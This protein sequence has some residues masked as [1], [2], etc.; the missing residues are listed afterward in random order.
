MNTFSLKNASY[1]ICLIVV[2]LAIWAFAIMITNIRTVNAEVKDSWSPE[3]A[4]DTEW[5]S[6]L[7]TSD[8]EWPDYDL[9]GF[10]KALCKK[11]GVDY[12]ENWYIF[13]PNCKCG[14]SLINSKNG[15]YTYG[16][17]SACLPVKLY[18]DKCFYPAGSDWKVIESKEL[19]QEV[20]FEPEPLYL[21]FNRELSAEE[22]KIIH[23]NIEKII[24]TWPDYIE[25]GKDLIIDLKGF[26]FQCGYSNFG[27]GVIKMGKGT[28]IYFK[29]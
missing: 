16:F 10:S 29:E 9:T 4:H 22:I 15:L 2:F 3:F 26:D 11:Q 13:C 28:R 7:L 14:A 12:S 6:R 24:P 1:S 8:Y 20:V 25:L 23:N 21:L 27:S 5:K 17:L 19:E 18:C